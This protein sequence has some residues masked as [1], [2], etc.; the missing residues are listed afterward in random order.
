MQFL[1]NFWYIKFYS[2]AG[3][4]QIFDA[5]DYLNVIRRLQGDAKE[6]Q[7]SAEKLSFV[8]CVSEAFVDCYPDSQ[9]PDALLNLLV[10]PDSL[11]FD[12]FQKLCL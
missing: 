10:I 4:R 1:L 5:L 3:A 9:G 12:T 7:F 11:C 2:L 6:E 8:H